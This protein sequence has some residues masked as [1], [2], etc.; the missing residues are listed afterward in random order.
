MQQR[1]WKCLLA[2]LVL[3]ATA[4]RA[5]N[6]IQNPDFDSGFTGWTVFSGTFVID[7]T[8][9][10]PAQPS[11][12]ATAA[13]ADGF[14]AIINSPCIVM[15]APQNV[16][17]SADIKYVSGGPPEVDLYGFTDMACAD[18]I[19]VVSISG[20]PKDGV[21][22]TSSHAGVSLP[23]G[24]QSVMVSIFT[25]SDT[26]GGSVDAYFDHILFGSTSATPVRLQSFDVE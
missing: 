9:G 7:A 23:D 24:T 13:P 21:W 15:S 3:Q 2:G 10:S 5:Q 18:F 22:H 11:L 19:N 20:A 4:A 1:K 8:D 16:D 12:H 17:L 26:L 6:L 14:E 25:G